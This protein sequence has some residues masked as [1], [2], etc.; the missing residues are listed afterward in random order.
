MGSETKICYAFGI[1]DKKFGYKS[2]ISDEKTLPGEHPE[3]WN[4]VTQGVDLRDRGVQNWTIVPIDIFPV[5]EFACRANSLV[6]SGE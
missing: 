6:T 1:K 4:P 5:G 2:G 3:L